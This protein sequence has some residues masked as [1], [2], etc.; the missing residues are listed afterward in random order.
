MQ[1]YASRVVIYEAIA[2]ICYGSV[3]SVKYDASVM[4]YERIVFYNVDH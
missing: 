2:L 1:I 3:C 4:N